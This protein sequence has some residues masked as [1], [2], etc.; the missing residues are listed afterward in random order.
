MC[1]GCATA[2]VPICS[3]GACG[4]AS[5]T[6]VFGTIGMALIIGAPLARQWLRETTARCGLAVLNKKLF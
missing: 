6:G 2:A 4:A 5:A 1:V 3:T